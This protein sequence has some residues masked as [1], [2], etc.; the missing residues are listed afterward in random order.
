MI[1]ATFK[2]NVNAFLS[3]NALWIALGFVG[4]ILITL[5]VLFIFNRKK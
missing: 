1:L 2:D 5:A 4:I 3:N